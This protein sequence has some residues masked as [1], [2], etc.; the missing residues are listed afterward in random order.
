MDR[1]API[2]PVILCKPGCN[3]GGSAQCPT[4]LAWWQ[5]QASWCFALLMCLLG[6]SCFVPGLPRH[7]AAHAVNT[8]HGMHKASC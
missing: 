8:V 1:P 2:G 6:V 5:R 7:P 3:G 4:E